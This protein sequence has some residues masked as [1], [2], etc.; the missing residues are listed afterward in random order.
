MIIQKGT[1]TIVI[2]RSVVQVIHAHETLH[3]IV[4][5]KLGIRCKE[6]PYWDN[7]VKYLLSLVPIMVRASIIPA[8]VRQALQHKGVWYEA[9]DRLES[10]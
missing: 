8:E 7:R 4:Q 6:N 9:L 2:P 5:G 1:T 10:K 3:A